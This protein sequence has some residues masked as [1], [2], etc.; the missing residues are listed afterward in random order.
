MS[1]KNTSDSYEV[2]YGK[3]PRNT[4]FKKGVSGNPKGRPKKA[5]DFDHELI[6]ESKSFIGRRKRISKHEVVIKQLMKQAMTGST[7]AVRIYFGL[8]QQAP[9]RVAVVAGPQANNSGKYDDVNTRT[10]EELMRFLVKNLPDEELERI[11]AVLKDKGQETKK[12][13]ISNAD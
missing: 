7:Q 2:G 9:E 8:H 1:K 3:P 10:D 5:L 13:H 4:Q 12:E 6:R 11:I